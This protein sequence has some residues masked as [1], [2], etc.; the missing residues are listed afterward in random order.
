MNLLIKP[1]SFMCN[2]DCTYC[3]YK[4][5]AGLYTAPRPMMGM[6]TA[7]TMIQKAL[8][9]GHSRNSFCWQGG[10]PTLMGLDFFRA[11][12]ALQSRLAAPG[13]LVENSIQTNGVLID[14]RWAG[15]LADNEILTGLSLDGPEG[16]HDR[17]RRD[18]RGRG[19]FA[20]V[21]KAAEIM[22]RRGA[23]F[24]ILTLLTPDNIGQPDALYAFF[25][26][27]GFTHLQFIPCADV[28]PQNGRPTV[29][30]VTGEALGRFYVRLFDLWIENGFP[31]VSIR[32]FEDLLLYMLDGVRASCAWLPACDSYLV[33]EHNGDVFPCDFYVADGHCLGNIHEQGVDELMM[34]AG[35]R[36][37]ANV[38]AEWPDE[39]RRCRFAGFCQA[40]CPRH[41][42]DGA[43]MFCRAW[44]MVFE[45]IES[46]SVDIRQMAMAARQRHAQ[47]VWAAVGRNDPCPCGSGRKYKKC[48]LNKKT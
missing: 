23:A 16:I 42:I 7:E 14:D 37:F 40:D 13:Q 46:H 8:A 19:S 17:H 39:C 11:V 25:L 5:T 2:L 24:N 4:R 35:R 1:A 27:R 43:S 48:C 12:V 30:A 20:Q 22:H 18:R 21:M 47:G 28:D 10:E 45:H 33:V 3:F 34:S 31:H 41:R 6:A 9:L 15:F 44:K 26:S 36:A 38:K 32:F 29:H